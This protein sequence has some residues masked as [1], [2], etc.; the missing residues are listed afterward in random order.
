MTN[1]FY[2][3]YLEEVCEAADALFMGEDAPSM[4]DMVLDSMLS[5]VGP[6]KQDRGPPRRAMPTGP[7]DIQIHARR[8]HIVVSLGLGERRGVGGQVIRNGH[9]W[10]A[11]VVRSTPDSFGI[12]KREL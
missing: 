11:A 3:A 12:P 2:V 4:T 7:G 10:S 8:P 5:S 9:L 6:R 1:A